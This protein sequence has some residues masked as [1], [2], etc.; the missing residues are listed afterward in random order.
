MD[1][2]LWGALWCIDFI[3]Y[4][5]SLFLEC[6]EFIDFISELDICDLCLRWNEGEKNLFCSP[7]FTLVS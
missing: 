7:S 3:S 1:K 2:Y 4:I 6:L 5:E